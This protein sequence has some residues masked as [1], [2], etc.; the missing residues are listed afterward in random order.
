MKK[1]M[2]DT[3]AIHEVFV[4]TAADSCVAAEKYMFEHRNA[5]HIPQ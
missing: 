3:M 2:F 5:I 4:F 1:A